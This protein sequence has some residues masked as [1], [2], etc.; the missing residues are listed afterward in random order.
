MFQIF[1]KVKD[2]KPHFRRLNASF[3][4]D[5]SEKVNAAKVDL[6]KAQALLLLIPTSYPVKKEKEINH[7]YIALK[8]VFTSRNPELHV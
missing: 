8:K 5:I 7:K 3:Y 2:G 6:E 1:C 4:G